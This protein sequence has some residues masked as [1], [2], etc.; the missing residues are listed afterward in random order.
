MNPSNKHILTQ[1]RRINS[2]RYE[3]D[4]NS[5]SAIPDNFH[6]ITFFKGKA[7]LDSS[8]EEKTFVFENYIVK[9]FE[10]FDFHDKFN[11]GIAPFDKVMYGFIIRETEKMYLLRLRNGLGNKV[12][13]GFC[14]KKSVKILNS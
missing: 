8:K 2:L 11:K 12:W 13:E 5:C 4:G 14:P 6:T 9:P 3:V 10:G 1:V 7:E